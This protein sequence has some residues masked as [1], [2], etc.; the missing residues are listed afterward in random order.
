MA[1]LTWVNKQLVVAVSKCPK[2]LTNVCPIGGIRKIDQG[3]VDDVVRSK[4]SAWLKKGKQ[5]SVK[6]A[7]SEFDNKPNCLW[8][9]MERGID[10]GNEPANL[11]S[12]SPC[13]D[14][15]RA[16]REREE[17]ISKAHHH[18]HTHTRKHT[19]RSVEEARSKFDNLPNGCEGSERQR[20]NPRRD[21]TKD[22]CLRAPEPK[23]VH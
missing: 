7:V 2:V 22:R 8:G 20:T 12:P 1:Y 21:S 11:S 16:C 6:E 5:R 4:A 15:T 14:A 3:D 17:W 23:I 18:R 19:W 13:K 9:T 10:P